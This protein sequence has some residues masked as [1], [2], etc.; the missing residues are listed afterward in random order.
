MCLCNTICVCFMHTRQRVKDTIFSFPVKKPKKSILTN[1]IEWT[2]KTIKPEKPDD[3]PILSVDVFETPIY[4]RLILNTVPMNQ[5]KWKHQMSCI[6]NRWV[7]VSECVCVCMHSSE[8][9]FRNSEWAGKE[10][11][12]RCALRSD[13]MNERTN[14]RE[15]MNDRLTDRLWPSEPNG[16]L[17][18]PKKNWRFPHS[19]H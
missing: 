13:R 9:V 8:C 4:V 3:Q 7:T 2:S 12:S 6:S 1:R 10:I 17:C 11:A 5:F 19:W 18:A 14:A 15:R 16:T